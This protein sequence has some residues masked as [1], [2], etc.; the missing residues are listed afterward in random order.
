MWVFFSERTPASLARR[1]GAYLLREA[2]TACAEIDLVSYDRLFPAQDFPPGEASATSLLSRRNKGTTVF[3]DPST[4]V[5]YTDQWEFLA[6]VDRLSR[7]AALVLAE[8][9]GDVPVGPDARTYR[10]PSRAPGWTLHLRRYGRWLPRDAG[11]GPHRV[12]TVLARRAYACRVIAQSRHAVEH[13]WGREGACECCSPSDRY[14]PRS[15]LQG[16]GNWEVPL[17]H[18][19]EF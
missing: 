15:R 16:R 9:F 8:N 13:V 1:I 18:D 2:M 10:R 19:L 14:P 12:A 3:L 5:R 4:L 11:G 7:E 6:P 17:E